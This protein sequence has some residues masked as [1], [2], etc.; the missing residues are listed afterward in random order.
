MHH[1]TVVVSSRLAERRLRD[2]AARTNTLGK[3][4]LTL[5]GLAARL[6]GGFS[7]APAA[8]EVR[9]LLRD[10]PTAGL[11]SLETVASLP[12]FARAATA[13]LFAVWHAGINLGAR[14]QQAGAPGRFRELAALEEHVRENLPA[15]VLLPPSLVNQ[16]T[17]RVEAAERLVGPV[18]LELV[19]EVP[20]LYRPLLRELAAFVE[21]TWRIPTPS[22][23]PTWARGMNV[24]SAPGK[25][26]AVTVFSCSDPAHEALE[27]L[28]WVR[29]LLARGVQAAE[30]AVATTD[31]SAYDDVILSLA[32][33]SSLP[34]HA[35]HGAA[36]LESAAGQYAA[37]FGE[38]LTYGPTPAR[39]RRLLGAAKAARCG[40]LGALPEDWDDYLKPRTQPTKA[41]HW[42]LAL[43]PLGAEHPNLATLIEKLVRDLELG[44]D[45]AAHLGERW[46]TGTA[47]EVWRAALT[48]G[49]PSAL[50]SS[51]ARLRTLDST[52]PAASVLWGPAAQL[53]T[54]PRA[55]VRLLGLSARSWPRRGSDEDPLLPSRLLGSTLRERST[56]RQDTAHFGA[57]VRG[58]SETLVISYPRRG[59]DGRKQTRSPL[60]RGLEHPAPTVE[61]TPH[62][63]T[64]ASV[65][66]LS[67]A[68]RRA[69]RP[70]ELWADPGLA[71]AR[72]AYERGFEPTLSA[73]DGLIRPGHPVIKRAIGRGHSATSL[74]RLL[75]N[76]HGFVASYG[77]G[78][79]EPEVRGVTLTLE[80]VDRGSFL[81]EVLELAL[82]EVVAAGGLHASSESDVAAACEAATAKIAEA[83]EQ[84]GPVPPALAWSTQQAWVRET[85]LKMLLGAGP[86]APGIRSY[87][88][89][90]FGFRRAEEGQHE[91]LP[92]PPHATV[93]LGA[94][95]LR[96]KGVIDRLDIDDAS[97]TV[98]VIDYKSGRARQHDG[99]LDNGEEL[100]RTLYTLASQQLLGEEYEVSAGLFYA[101]RDEPL[102]LADPA[103]ATELLEE[104]VIEGVRL[105]GAGVAVPGPGLTS[106]FEETLLA[107]PAVGAAHYLAVKAD[108]ISSKRARI[109]ALLAGTPLEGEA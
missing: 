35:A 40:K 22:E 14:A 30:I 103:A 42:Q 26:P 29:S 11:G 62:T 78:W 72:R 67:E 96:L 18:T 8:T 44:P 106:P 83:W 86:T 71:R 66:A 19:G 105:L 56:A 63:L 50:P 23:V 82:K 92:F 64:G 109:D 54:W 73:F 65:H 53:L 13:T 25:E 55:H 24:I 31:V 85:A 15:G 93:K 2:E 90:R 38:A 10:A 37:A 87:A 68:D 4:V 49:P 17:T 47:L 5:S 36:T 16:A 102:L 41:A 57:L 91:G 20:P 89:V 52:D 58:T 32:R 79:K 80:P 101:D 81:H 59:A 104:A 43:R 33:R 51:L 100:Q 75:L 34:V 48:E 39:V 27:A 3:R 69:L 6:A 88:E 84:S 98:R 99:H 70:N 7:R 97:N 94:T 107:Q 60:L 61:L 95:G 12:G 1:S 28:R 77:L 21:L 46:L 74:R 45:H 108:A 76:P 9:G